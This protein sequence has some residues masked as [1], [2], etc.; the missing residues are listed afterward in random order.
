M[1]HVLSISNRVGDRITLMQY[2]RR[3]C[4][5]CFVEQTTIYFTVNDT[6]SLNNNHTTEGTLII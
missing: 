1:C 5:A 6:K 2:T 3:V 4:T